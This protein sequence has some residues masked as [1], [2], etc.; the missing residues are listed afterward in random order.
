MATILCPRCN[1]A[2]PEVETCTVCNYEGQQEIY[3]CPLALLDSEYAGLLIP[4]LMLAHEG[5]LWP[6]CGGLD[7]QSPAFVEAVFE[8]RRE[9]NEFNKRTAPKPNG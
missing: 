8:Y 7:D 1:G 9:L 2:Y 3:R 5:N 6:V 4:A